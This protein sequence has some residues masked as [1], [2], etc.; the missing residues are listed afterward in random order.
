MGSLLFVLV[1]V[2]CFV[3]LSAWQVD[4]AQHKNDAVES[5]DVEEVEPFNEVMEAQAPMPGILADQRVSLSGHWL[6]DA[7][8][9]VPGRVLDGDKG[10]WVVT[11]FAPDD[12]RLGAS[13]GADAEDKT[14]AIPVLRGFTTDE[15]TAMESRAAEGP[16]K[17]TAQI[18]PVEGP[19]PGNSLPEG[20][21][22]SVSTS[23]L[24]NLFPDLLTYSGFLIPESATGDAASVATDG[25][26]FVPPTTT[27]DE[28]GFDLQS[29]GYAIEWLI[30]AGMALY[31]WWQLLRDDFMRRRL[32][33]GSD[34]QDPANRVEYVVVKSAGLSSIDPKVMS[35]LTGLPAHRHGAKK[36][37]RSRGSASKSS[38]DDNST[39]TTPTGGN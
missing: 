27:R 15:K 39:N 33:E 4:R 2:T 18:G 21:V 32:G 29:A 13:V 30:F 34:S 28:G 35:G 8:V 17:M 5:A 26:A 1:L 23:Q 6:P 9:V 19:M 12:A 37:R 14:I 38:T 10:F 3:G 22:R 7:Q 24:I 31:M 11:M 25:L 36:P 16:V 20:Q